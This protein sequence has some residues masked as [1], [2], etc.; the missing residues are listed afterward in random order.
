MRW[1]FAAYGFVLWPFWSSIGLLRTSWFFDRDEEDWVAMMD[2][3][4]P[5]LLGH[6]LASILVFSYE[7]VINRDEQNA[8]SKM[9]KP[10]SA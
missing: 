8:F 6:S 3:S 5:I 7:E 1:R 2:C 10:K 4:A 9:D